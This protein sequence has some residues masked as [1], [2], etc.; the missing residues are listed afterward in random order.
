MWFM[1]VCGVYVFYCVR[2][3]EGLEFKKTRKPSLRKYFLPIAAFIPVVQAHH[4]QFLILRFKND[5]TYINV[6]III[7]G[8]QI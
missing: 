8:F 7:Y 6:N 2:G 4:Q 1:D 5:I 3:W